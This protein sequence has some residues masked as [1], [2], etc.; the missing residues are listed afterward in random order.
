MAATTTSPPPTVAAEA[1]LTVPGIAGLQPRLIHRLAAAASPT[2]PDTTPHPAPPETGVRTAPL[3]DGTGWHI[4]VRCILI[5]G[6][7]AVDT[8]RHVHDRVRAA[9]LSYLATHGAPVAVTV[10]VTVTI[11][12]ITAQDHPA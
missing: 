2:R 8:A 12:R 1:A 10:T 3:P 9:A 4:E 6:H 7:R 5:E 11:T